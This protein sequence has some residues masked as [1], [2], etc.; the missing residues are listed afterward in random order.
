[1]LLAA[2]YQHVV[3]GG[4]SGGREHSLGLWQDPKGFLRDGA[5]EGAPQDASGVLRRGEQ[6]SWGMPKKAPGSPGV[7]KEATGLLLTGRAAGPLAAH[8]GYW[9]FLPGLRK[10]SGRRNA[11]RSVCPTG[12]EQSP[13]AS[14][15]SAFPGMPR[16]AGALPVRPGQAGA[17]HG[18]V[19]GFGGAP[20]MGSRRPGRAGAM[21]PQGSPQGLPTLLSPGEPKCDVRAAAVRSELAAHTALGRVGREPTAAVW[22]LPR[23]GALLR[24]GGAGLLPLELLLPG[25]ATLLGLSGKS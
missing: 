22:L 21:L 7:P 1:M 25:Q 19:A 10:G 17:W 3:L 6:G 20:G 12:R 16:R 15:L 4:G 23:A 24:G 9:A 18:S 8:L 13:L 5:G 2:V 11:A 14:A